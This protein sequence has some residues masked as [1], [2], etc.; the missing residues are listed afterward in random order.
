MEITR[1]NN[2]DKLAYS[3]RDTVLGEYALR[4]YFLL[5]LYERIS[6]AVE[7]ITTMGIDLVNDFGV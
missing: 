5:F 2:N 3:Q 1:L 6:L 4:M 7:R